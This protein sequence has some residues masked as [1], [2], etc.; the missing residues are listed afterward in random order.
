MEEILEAHVV[1]GLLVGMTSLAGHILHLEHVWHSICALC[2]N[3]IGSDCP[4]RTGGHSHFSLG[5]CEAINTWKVW[6][7]LGAHLVQCLSKTNFGEQRSE[8]DTSHCMHDEEHSEADDSYRMR[9]LTNSKVTPSTV[10]GW[11]CG[12]RGCGQGGMT[13][14]SLEGV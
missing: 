14:C 8:A 9:I 11:G 10:D 7:A 12:M 5:D 13:S 1:S 3:H 6:G 2:W 4:S